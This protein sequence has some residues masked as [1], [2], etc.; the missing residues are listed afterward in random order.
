MELVES[1]EARVSIRSFTEEDVPEKIVNE[2]LRLAILAPSAGNLQARDFIVVRN[3]LSKKRLAK[4]AFGQAFIEEAPVNIVVCANQNR[5]RNYGTRGAQ[6]YCLQDSAA[7]I[8]HILL[9]VVSQGFGSCWVGAF[10]E[11]EV[12]KVLSIPDNVRP[13]AVLPIGRPMK[14]GFH[15]SRLDTNEVVHKEK[16]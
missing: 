14:E 12:S 6:L 2:A 5:I 10:D 15:T 13:V 8:E 3:G 4:A 11:R 16:W 1:I 7:A 9:Y